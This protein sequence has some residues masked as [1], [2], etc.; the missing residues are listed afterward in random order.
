[1]GTNRRSSSSFLTAVD[2]G[3]GSGGGGTVCRNGDLS[4]TI[5]IP[6]PGPVFG[7]QMLGEATRPLHPE[8]ASGAL[9]HM[10]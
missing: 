6:P 7:H 9:F 2:T 5:A 4:S 8:G 1:M 3:E 10:F